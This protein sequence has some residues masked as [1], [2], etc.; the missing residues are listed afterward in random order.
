MIY[1]SFFFSQF[2]LTWFCFLIGH[3]VSLGGDWTQ[4][5]QGH[6]QG[7]RVFELSP[8]EEASFSAAYQGPHGK[9]IRTIA[10]S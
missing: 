10:C 3:S 1:H 5:F 4:E 8:E 9:N 6:Q 2:F 7:A